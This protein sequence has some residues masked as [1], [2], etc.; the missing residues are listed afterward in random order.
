LD[1]VEHADLFP[2]PLLVLL[3]G[4]SDDFCSSCCGEPF[5]VERIEALQLLSPP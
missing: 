3:D 4:C 2:L 5:V 1:V